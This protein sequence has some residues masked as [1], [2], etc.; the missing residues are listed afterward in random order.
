[1]GTTAPSG[2]NS[3]RRWE[4]WAVAVILA[5]GLALRFHSYTDAP[6]FN[7]NSDEVQF[8]WAGMNLIEHGDPYTWSYYPGYPSYTRFDAN[9]ISYPL[10]HHWMDH[11]PLFPYLLGGWVL[12]LGDKGMDQVTAQQV[13]VLP[14]LFSV[15]AVFLAYLLSRQLFGVW[16]SLVATALLATAPGA[17]LLSREVEPESLQAVLLL[18]SL[19]LT[20]RI[21]QMGPSR[22]SFGML[23]ALSLLAPLAKVSGFAIAGTCAVILVAEGRWRT[24]AATIAAGLG[25]LLLFGLYG[26]IV[27]WTLFVSIWSHQVGN[28][29]GVMAGFDFITAMAGVNRPLRDGWWILGWIGLGLL[30]AG[31]GRRRELYLIWPAAAYAATMLVMA[32]GRQVDQYGW[33]KVIVYPEI[34]LAAGWLTWAA[35][36]RQSLALL[37]LLLTLGGATATNWWLGGVGLG[38]TW[39][40]NP[41]VL[42]VLL[43]AVL[44]PAAIAMWR[45]GDLRIKSWARGGAFAAL[46]IMLLGNGVESFYLDRI[47]AFM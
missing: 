7:D 26:A 6:L 4:P 43:L 23:L 42:T 12:L 15:V 47:F 18:A 2:K 8:A 1:M 36:S 34:Y 27:D 29:N 5:L 38:Q 13:R 40:P 30:A 17:V 45:R 39:L 9:G 32:G 14:I 19:L 35:V 31:R 24:A 44:A 22:W 37:T 41:A 33:Y 46:T 10:V 28:R 11:P 20:L 3:W 25:G 16:P 21:G